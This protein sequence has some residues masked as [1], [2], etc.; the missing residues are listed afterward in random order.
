MEHA[1]ADY[2]LQLDSRIKELEK[3]AIETKPSNVCLSKTVFAK[4]KEKKLMG[5]MESGKERKGN[6]RKDITSQNQEILG[7]ER[8]VSISN[9]WQGGDKNEIKDKIVRGFCENTNGCLN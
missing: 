7:F 5:D 6:K 2:R 1:L 8:E 3:N 4:E 9:T